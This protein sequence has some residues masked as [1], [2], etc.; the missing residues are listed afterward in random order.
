MIADPDSDGSKCLSA[1]ALGYL[2]H[3]VADTVGHAF[4]NRIVESPWR[5]M[6]QRHHLVENFIDAHVWA[7]WHDA[8]S[9][10]ASPADETNLDTMSAQASDPNRLG[11]AR[12]NYA[13]LN[14]LCNIG[15]AGVD[16]II[17]NAI[18]SICNLIQQGL[19]DIGA[20]SVPSLQVPDDPI[21]TT[22]T[23]FISDTMWQTYPPSQD[24]PTKLGR[25]PTPDDVAGAYGAYRLVLSLAT[26]DKVDAPVPPNIVDDLSSILSQM[27]TNITKDLSAVPPPPSLGGGG[28][29]SLE[30]VWD[31]LKAALQW[32]GQVADAALNA[33]GDLIAG[34]IEAGTAA[35]ADTIKAGLYL[36]NS[37]LYSIYHSLRM[38]LVMSAY[39]AP[40]T[41][42]L[43]ATWG[44]LDLQTLWNVSGPADAPRFPIRAGGLSEGLRVQLGQSILALP[45]LLPAL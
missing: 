14:D 25:Y 9:D 17:D 41:E 10:P 37:I 7:S 45:A 22:W 38:T 3:Y 16:P 11:A 33:L 42:D 39:S 24:H 15:S 35:G 20:S 1:Y 19:F 32:F 27:W 12:L 43:T 18:T 8:G 23:E 28:G 40:F 31:A 44:P 4:V 34:L 21:F 5:N 13:R 26:E 2:T 36:I 30:S 6:W 29:I